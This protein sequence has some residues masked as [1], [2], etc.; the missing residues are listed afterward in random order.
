MTPQEHEAVLAIAIHAA[1]AGGAKD[2]REEVRRV[3]ASLA[4]ESNAPDLSR[5]YQD[6]LLKSWPLVA[7]PRKTPSR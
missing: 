2:E 6:V 3:A 4:D 1:F 5:P 7:V